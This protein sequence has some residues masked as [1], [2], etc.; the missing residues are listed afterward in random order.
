[1]YATIIFIPII[2]YLRGVSYWLGEPF[3]HAENVWCSWDNNYRYKKRVE[4]DNKTKN[5]KEFGKET[6]VDYGK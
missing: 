6:E 2:H 3:Y 5:K 4:K 1:M